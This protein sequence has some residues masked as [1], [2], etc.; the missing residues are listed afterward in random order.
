MTC[1]LQN[2]M[3]I[4]ERQE[5]QISFVS[6][7]GQLMRPVYANNA[8]VYALYEQF[9]I[10]HTQIELYFSICIW[11]CLSDLWCRKFSQIIIML[12]ILF[13]SVLIR[14]IHLYIYT[15]NS[16]WGFVFDFQMSRYTTTRNQYAAIMRVH[17]KISLSKLWHEKVITCFLYLF[18]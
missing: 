16:H 2:F 9:P 10:Y 11:L 18:I 17:E 13:C 8:F 5:C 3:W 7:L 4:P 6:F 1:W 15:N 14:N 12:T